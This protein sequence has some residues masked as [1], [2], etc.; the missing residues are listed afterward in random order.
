VPAQP[1]PPTRVSADT[2]Q[3]TIAWVA[4]DGRGLAI[5]LYEVYW[6]AGLGGS[7]NTLLVSTASDVLTAS[8]T[9]K[10][11]DLNDGSTYNFAIRA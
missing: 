4:A 8:T 7:P 5:T 6:D 1:S 10:L 9:A 11:A 3:I 2:T